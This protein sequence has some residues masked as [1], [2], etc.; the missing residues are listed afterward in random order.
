MDYYGAPVLAGLSA[1]HS[2][3]D[4][5]YLY[6]PEVIFDPV[7]SMYPDFIVKKYPG[8]YLTE[9]YAEDIVEFGKRC[10]SIL[11]GPG[12]G[13]RERTQESIIKISILSS[14]YIL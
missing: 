11:I 9:K 1:L 5:V 12:I 3:A 2:G 4:L 10:D 6:V 8:E 7:R 13:N 14:S